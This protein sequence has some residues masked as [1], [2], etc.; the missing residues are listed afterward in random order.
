MEGENMYN[1]LLTGEFWMETIIISACISA[2]GAVLAAML[3]WNYYL[4]K[5]SE[6]V[7]E[8]KG[9]ADSRRE[10]HQKLSGEHQDIRDKVLQV[11]TEQQ[12]QQAAREAAREEAE[13]QIPQEQALL[14]MMEG[15]C[16]HS[17]QLAS[18]NSQL[19][20]LVAAQQGQIEKQ[21]KQ[22]H[23]LKQRIR[24]K[25]SSWDEELER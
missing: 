25:D 23:K 3:A 18:E 4:K 9:Q 7:K 24:S 10:E 12:K 21:Q 19:K 1:F 22:I 17:S 5:T 13:K 15:V 8:I 14:K 11:L 2:A 6:D 16:L 20:G